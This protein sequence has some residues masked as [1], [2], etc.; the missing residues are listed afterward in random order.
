MTMITIGIERPGNAHVDSTTDKQL[1]V[2]FGSV[3]SI[4]FAYGTLGL[5]WSFS[6]MANR[7]LLSTASHVAFFGFLS[8]MQDPRD[9]PKTIAL[10][11][12]VDIGLYVVAAVV[13]Y[14]Y[15]GEHVVS[16]ALGSISPLPAKVAYGLAIPTVC[17]SR[18]RNLT[19]S[20]W[21]DCHRWCHQRPCRM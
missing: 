17:I 6:F 3:T 16:P 12:G 13:I 8:E 7:S 9:F 10:L 21:S 1:Y 11:Q 20:I 5:L 15:G 14:R 18:H 19:D 4:V 2:A